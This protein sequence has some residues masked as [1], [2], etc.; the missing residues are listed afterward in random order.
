MRDWSSGRTLLITS[1]RFVTGQLAVRIA[2]RLEALETFHVQ[3]DWT[4]EQGW[5]APTITPYHM[6]QI[7]PVAS[8]LQYGMECFEG[9]KAYRT[10]EGGVALFRP[11]MNAARLGRSMK[12]L[13]MPELDE[14]GFVDCISA[15]VACEEPWIPTGGPAPE[16][17]GAYSLYIRPT[18]IATWPQLGVGSGRA[19][20]IFAVACPVGPYYPE[21]EP[22][23]CPTWP[24]GCRLEG[25][26]SAVRPAWCPTPLPRVLSRVQAGAPA[27]RVEVRPRVAGRGRRRKGTSGDQGGD[28]G[29][30]GGREDCL[31][32]MWRA[33]H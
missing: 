33:A 4:A 22:L 32:H 17:G 13:A 23:P 28:Q 30:A 25:D 12:R 31:V 20:K 19:F 26:G 3:I 9:L 14:K 15:F 6:L 16:D 1:L 27:G 11:A 10:R 29:G 24:A 18:A 21:G 2:V 8:C 5:H 7:D